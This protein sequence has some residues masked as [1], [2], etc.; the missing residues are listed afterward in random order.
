MDTQK[1]PQATSKYEKQF[2]FVCLTES[3][4]SSV[5]VQVLMTSREVCTFS[6]C[7]I[8]TWCMHIGLSQWTAELFGHCSAG[9]S[10]PGGQRKEVCQGLGDCGR[11]PPLCVWHR[12]RLVVLFSQG[13][14][15][16]NAFQGSL[17]W[18]AWVSF[19]S[20]SQVL[21]TDHLTQVLHIT[22]ATLP[23]LSEQEREDRHFH[24][25][26]EWNLNS[27]YIQAYFEL[28]RQPMKLVWRN[29][30]DQQISIM[31]HDKLEFGF[32]Y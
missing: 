22:L 30:Q 2:P 11:L 25:H 9:Y 26:K 27:I 16:M 5:S 13:P 10:D 3:S 29:W 8:N 20:G 19:L 1:T 18:S 31:W 17:A 12:E 14:L 15:L 24:N 28:L 32:S 7:L 4:R 23:P 21:R 6:H